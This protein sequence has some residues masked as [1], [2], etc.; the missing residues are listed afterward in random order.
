[1]ADGDGAAVDVDD[2]AVD[3]RQVVQG[4]EHHGRERLVDLPEV[5]VLDA[6]AGT[7]QRLLDGGHGRDAEPVGLDRHGARG[8]DATERLHAEVLGHGR[9]ADERGQGPVVDGAGVGGRDRAVTGER[10][11]Q[12]GE[13]LH[14]RVRPQRLI[15]LDP[16]TSMTKPSCLPSS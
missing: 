15:A 5:D 12:R 1:M 9:G 4:R 8:D 11:L 2:L 7:L 3:L 6:Q 13:R 16:S 10:G 14:R